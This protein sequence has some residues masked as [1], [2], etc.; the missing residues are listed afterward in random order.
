MHLIP[1]IT[2]CTG[3]TWLF[4]RASEAAEVNLRK[5]R[6]VQDLPKG[7]TGGVDP[8]LVVVFFWGEGFNT[9]FFVLT[10]VNEMFKR[11]FMAI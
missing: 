7:P 11:L 2:S 4:N 5:S 10:L 3:G 9:V 8:F 6:T 1:A